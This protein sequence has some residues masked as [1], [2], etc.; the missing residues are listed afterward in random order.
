MPTVRVGPARQET[1]WT[2]YLGTQRHDAAARET[3]NPDPRPLWHTGMGRGVRG[4]PAIA[5]AV[6]AVGTA[7]R[8]VTLVDRSSGDVIWRS[9]LDGTVRSGPLLDEDRLYIGSEAQPDGRVYSLRLRDGKI[10]WRARTGSVVA[11]L[12]FDGEALY[13]GTEEGVALRIETE[14]GRIQWRAPLA[15]A[16]RAGPVVTPYGVVVATTADSL[17]LIDRGTGTVH[18]RLRLPGSVLGTP[19]SDGKRIYLGTVSGRIVAVDVA[20]W[21]TAWDRAAGDAVYGAPALVNDTLYVLARNGRLWLIPVNAPDSARSH[22]L[23]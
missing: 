12:A 20:S 21:T 1:A 22:T 8:N 23:D 15:G 19:A 10:Q 18:Q 2:A 6:I 14:R 16:I 13:A 5:E 7:D 3:L 17:Y 9:R 11:P 4:S